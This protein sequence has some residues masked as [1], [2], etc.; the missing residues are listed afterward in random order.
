[1]EKGAKPYI[2]ESERS[3][4]V[5]LNSFRSHEQHEASA[6]TLRFEAYELPKPVIPS[7][8]ATPVMQSSSSSALVPVPEPSYPTESF[9]PVAPVSST[10]DAGSSD[11]RLRLD[12]VQKKWGRSTYS[13]SSTSNTDTLTAQ[14][15]APQRESVTSSNSRAR[16]FSYD[17]RRQQP[18]ISA[19]KQKLAASLFGGAAK[20]DKRQSPAS[21]K[22]SKT[23][24]QA[25]E[26]SHGVKSAVSE[27]AL[28]DKIVQPP[29]DLLDLGEASV[30][31]APT[32]VDPFK[33]LE[34]LLDL[35]ENT[36]TLNS[37]QGSAS[38]PDF[39]SL[40]GETTSNEQSSRVV[41]PLSGFSTTTTAEMN[42]H[43][44]STGTQT[45]Q[46]LSKGVSTKDSLERDALVRQLGVTPTGQNPNLFKDLLG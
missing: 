41:D 4:M 16:E 45:T 14:N 1:M 18:E 35:S 7:K 27:S 10:S 17:S 33:Q 32:S 20:S 2:P 29:P 34:G 43:G 25:V 6:H 26:K 28:A 46:Q 3:G 38:A 39:M 11:L 24:T 42:G 40:Y 22:V 37:R 31:S 12:G 9:Q 13:T 8:T 15:G 19:E 5:D 21:Q 36:C 23:P 30:S 44:A